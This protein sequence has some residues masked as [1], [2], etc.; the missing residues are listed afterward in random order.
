M[1][2]VV[3]PAQPVVLASDGALSPRHLSEA[4]ENGVSAVIQPG[5]TSE[6]RDS[7]RLADEVDL[8]MIFTGVRHYRH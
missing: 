1:D 4:A 8:S 6:D 5:G 3:P 7:I 2:P